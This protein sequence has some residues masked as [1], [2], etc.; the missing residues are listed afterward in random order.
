M[1]EGQEDFIRDF[2][3]LKCE[4][5]TGVKLRECY[6]NGS[7]CA[8][9]QGEVEIVYHSEANLLFGSHLN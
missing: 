9:W 4:K 5:T 3:L 8:Q 6:G 1:L 7:R 2:S